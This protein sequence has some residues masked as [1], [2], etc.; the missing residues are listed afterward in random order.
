MKKVG[1]ST[2]AHKQANT[3]MLELSRFRKEKITADDRRM[4]IG[5]NFRQ[6]IILILSVANIIKSWTWKADG[7]W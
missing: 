2:D 1:A 5:R 4:K 3:E 7:P 6:P